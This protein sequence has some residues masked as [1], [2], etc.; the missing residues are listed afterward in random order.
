MRHGHGLVNI[1]YALERA[2]EIGQNVLLVSDW[3]FVGEMGMAREFQ[4]V[5]QLLKK[6]Q[7]PQAVFVA[8][9][10]VT[11]KQSVSTERIADDAGYIILRHSGVLSHGRKKHFLNQQRNPII[12]IVKHKR[13]VVGSEG[14][15]GSFN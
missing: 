4:K 11:Q 13:H 2:A 6:N 3:T 10:A 7:A 8:E 15:V 1:A 9:I 5:P 12:R 14:F